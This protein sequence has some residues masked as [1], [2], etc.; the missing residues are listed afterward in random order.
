MNILKSPLRRRCEA[1]LTELQ[2]V[3]ESSLSFPKI[4]G[5]IQRKIHHIEIQIDLLKELLKKK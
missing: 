2:A 3:R 1:R 5:K 4:D